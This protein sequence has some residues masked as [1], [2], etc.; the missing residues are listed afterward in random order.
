MKRTTFSTLWATVVI[1]AGLSI[2]SMG[3]V[4]Q[5]S[6]IVHYNDT[7]VIGTDTLGGVT[8]STVASDDLF[9]DGEP[10]KPSLPVDFLRF[11]VPYNA[12]NFSVT[13]TW[14]INVSHNLSHL[15]Y[16][17]QAP[18]WMNDTT[19]IQVTLPDTAAYYSGN[20]YPSQMAWVVDEGFLAGEN[21]IVT[22]AVMPFSYSHTTTSD[23]VYQK[24]TITV[25]LSYEL[26]D[27]LA[28]YPIITNDSVL[29]EEGYRLTQTM[30]VNPSQVAS[31]SYSYNP[32]GP[33]GPGNPI[34]PNGGLPGDGLNGGLDPG[35]LQPGDPGSIG[36]GGD[37]QLAD[38]KFRYLIVTT[39]E[40]RHSLRR[41]AA[42]KMQK[43]YS[44]KIVTIDEVLADSCASQGDLIKKSDGTY[45]VASNNSAGKLRQYLKNCRENNGTKYVLL[46]GTSIPYGYKE[47]VADDGIKPETID[48]ISDFYYSE[49]NSD[50][51]DSTIRDHA[52]ELYVGRIL[53]KESAQIDNYTNKL[54]RY[55][56]NP[57]CGNYSYLRKVLFEEGQLFVQPLREFKN[58][59]F[60]V[61]PI[62][63]KIELIESYANFRPTGKE[64]IDTLNNTPVG[65]ITILHHGDTTNTMVSTDGFGHYHVIKSISTAISGNGLNCLNNRDYPMV[66]Y[67]P[68]C[69]TV[70]FDNRDGINM[71]ESF[72]TG[73]DYG[74]PVYMGYTRKVLT[75]TTSFITGCFAERLSDGYFT[76]GKADALS[77]WDNK[78]YIF[79]N[80]QDP[81]LIHAYI[82]DP[83]VDIWTAIPHLYRSIYV[84]RT[85]HSIN[86]SG[87]DT[88]STIVAYCDNNYI[89]KQTVNSY[90]VSLN[91]SPNASVMIY[92][93]NCIPYIIP[94][95]LQN[96]N[97]FGSKYMI[98]G[99]FMAGNSVDSNRTNGDVV[100]KQGAN[101][102]IEAAGTTRLCGG[103]QVEPGASFSIIPSSFEDEQYLY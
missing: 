40:F 28:I 13:T 66:F 86:I 19:P 6:Y 5:I 46:A 17:C 76:L 25:K 27:S 58:Y 33:I 10:G 77:V 14:R 73:K 62:N 64:V 43:G 47:S 75:G 89:Y 56:L 23:K 26:S 16:P 44:V 82:G 12:T 48:C 97:L 54:F 88:D 4:N 50:W 95:V 29:R 15:I 2:N 63:K 101:Y 70:P 9:N 68:A 22:V 35:P 102:E 32:P 81:S 21:H 36:F 8:Y 69:Q 39:N 84:T 92:R 90:N 72:T 100:V 96:V 94:T 31:F 60:N 20:T 61:F 71:G 74:G 98:A 37:L 59:I 18:R 57:G 87:I 103:F 55:E 51:S 79:Q 91:C 1:M 45:Y 3:A 24:K 30:V 42:L 7:P 80:L 67:A 49:L 11:S 85:D 41:L 53:A 34:D 38:S 78:Y 83:L 93:H 99:D 65:L 52:A